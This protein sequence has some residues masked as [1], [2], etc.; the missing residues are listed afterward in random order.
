MFS[1]WFPL[2]AITGFS[3]G[4]VLQWNGAIA[5]PLTD[6]RVKKLVREV[7]VAL[8]NQGRRSARIEDRLTPGDLL[9]TRKASRADLRFNDGTFARVGELS[10]FSFRPNQRHYDL[11]KGTFLFVIPPGQGGGTFRTPNATA[12]VRGSALFIRYIE[13]DDITVVGAL[14]NNP[15]GP[16]EI[17]NKSGEQKLGLRAGEM[18]VLQKDKIIGLYEFD[19]R[20]FYETSEMVKGLDLQGRNGRHSDPDIAKVQEETVQAL[21]EQV[22][23]AGAIAETPDILKNPAHRLVKAGTPSLPSTVAG[24]A[25]FDL[26]NP[27]LPDARIQFNGQITGTASVVS[28]PPGNSSSVSLGQGQENRGEDR[29]ASEQPFLVRAQNG[30][31]RVEPS[32]LDPPVPTPPAPQP[33]APIPQPPAPQPPAPIPQPPAPQPPAPIPQPPAPQPPAPI[34]QPPAPQ[35]PAPIPQPPAPQPPQLPNPGLP[36]PGTPPGLNNGTAPNG[37]GNNG[38]PPGL[39]NGTAPDPGLSSLRNPPSTPTPTTVPSL[40]ASQNS[41]ALPPALN[42][43]TTPPGL[44][45]TP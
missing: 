43:S 33:P 15:T 42:T 25:A 2:A 41:S 45:N 29:G 12:G 16:M 8:K 32:K 40:D 31:S 20:R 1:K 36:N 27:N 39:N 30:G 3:L 22:P 13:E 28:P 17:E 19:L 9:S 21:Q 18:V 26:A 24:G 5:A 4:L 35:P 34:P 10:T 23:F 6:A 7:Q 14:T 44:N 37:V 38:T 11:S